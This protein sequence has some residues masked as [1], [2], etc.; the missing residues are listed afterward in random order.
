MRSG[1]AESTGRRGNTLVKLFVCLIASC[2]LCA[3]WPH[4]AAADDPVQAELSPYAPS[5]SFSPNGD[6]QEDT[7]SVPYCL[8]VASNVDVVVRDSAN[9]LVRTL[10]SGVSVPAT[11]YFNNGECGFFGW[12]DYP[13]WDGLNEAGNVVADGDYTIGI[14]A[15][16]AGGNTADLSYQTA[17]DTRLLG[18]LTQPA[19]NAVVSG[20]AGFVFVPT[21]GVDVTSVS[22]SC[23]GS[24][25]AVEADGTFRGSEDTHD[26][27]NG[28]VDVRAYVTFVDEFGTSH[29]WSPPDL[30]ITIDNPVQAVLSSYVPPQ[31]FSP[32]GDGQEDAIAIP[33]CLST[34][35]TV[36]VVVRDSA[37]HVVRTLESGVSV[38][39]SPYV[40]SLCGYYGWSDYPSWDGLNDAG[41]VV[42]DGDYTI[43][44]HAV[45]AGGNTADLSYQ[46]AVD[47]RLPG[48]LTQPAPNAAVSGTAGFVFVPTAGVDVTSVS[49]P[50]LGSS[51]DADAD[52]TFRGSEDTHDCANGATDVA[53]YVTFVDEF[54]TSHSWSPPTVP[55]T[56]DN[57]VQV[58]PVQADLG[59]QVSQ[60]FSPNGDGQE[61]AIAVPYC[62]SADSNVDVVVRDSANHV[63]RT[64][65]SG[66]SVPA[67]QYFN[68]SAC[69][70]YGWSDYPS[71]DGLN[72]AGNVVADGD[73][74][75]GIHAVDAGGNS[76]DLSYH[77][78][79]DTRVPGNLTQPAAND[80]LAGLAHFAFNPTAGVDVT[81]VSGCFSTGGCV[82]I[83]NPSPDGLWRTSKFTGQLSAGPATFSWSAQFTDEFG[84]VHSWDGTDVPVSINTTTLPLSVTATRTSGLVPL[85]TSFTINASDPNARPLNYSVS[86]GDGASTSGT[87]TSPYNPVVV[88]HSYATAGVFV[89]HVTI[90][91]GVG[92]FSQQ[93]QTITVSAPADDPPVATLT[94]SPQ[95]GVAPFHTSAAISASDPDNDALSYTLDWGDGSTTASGSIPSGSLSHTYTRAGAFTVRLGVGD[96]Q[97]TTVRTATVNVGLSEPLAANP[98]DDVQAVVGTPVA[99]DGSASRPLIG[100]DS[101]TWNFGDGSPTTTGAQVNHVFST[102][103][104]R[105]VSLT[106]RSGIHTSTNTMTVNVVPV[107]TVPGLHV[108][109]TD[110]ATSVLAGADVT[111]ID[112]SGVRYS[113]T[114]DASGIA[115][116]Q[117]LQDGA[118]SVYAWLD[119]YLPGTVAATI[120]GGTGH[121]ELALD[122]GAVA[123]TALTADRLTPQQ[124]AAVG[125]DP[126]DPAN[127]NAYQFEIHLAF[128][129]DPAQPPEDVGFSGYTIGGGGSGGGGGAF[130]GAG[131][132]GGATCTSDCSETVGNYTVY[133][134]VQ[135]IA[136]QPSI[137]W[138][139]IPGKAK[140][141]KEFFDVRLVV[142]NLASDAFTLQNGQAS[143]DSLPQGLSLA[144]TAAPQSLT[145]AVADIPGGTSQEAD[146]IIRG[147]TEGLYT[148]TAD[149]TGSL[150]PIG[151]S[152]SLPASTAPNAL[153]VWGESAVKMIVDA[154]DHATAAYPYHVR[155]GLQNVA[156]IPVYNAG[157]EL[158]TQGK[159]NY[160]YQPR[161]QLAQ[162]DDVIQPGSTFW[163]S[164]VLVPKISGTLDLTDSFVKKT[165]GNVDPPDLIESHPAVI[166]PANA[167]KF[168][169][170]R[171]AH[172]VAFTWDDVAGASNYQL[173]STPDLGTDFPGSPL[174][175]TFRNST[176]AY[177]S[178]I[179]DT[180]TGWYALSP[181]IAGRP[182]LHHPVLNTS[183]S[184]QYPALSVQHQCSGTEA[185]V[186]VTD[187]FFS[188][189]SYTITAQGVAPKTG[190]LSGQSAVIPVTL[191]RAH[192]PVGGYTIHVVNS[193]LESANTT[194]SA[195]GCSYFALGDSYSSG[196]GAVTSPTQ[197]ESGTD[198][199]NIPGLDDSVNTCH[200]T[201]NAYSGLLRPLINTGGAPFEFV[202]CSGA[203]TANI[204]TTA[205]FPE[206]T[207]YG[208][209]PQIQDLKDFVS[210]YGSP[211]V[212]TLS[213]GGNDA[214]FKS[215]IEQ[216]LEFDCTNDSRSNA[217]M[218]QVQAI[219]TPVEQ[220]LDAIKTAAPGSEIY[221]LGYPIPVSPDTDD[222]ASLGVQIGFTPLKL[223]VQ[224]RDWVAQELSPYLDSVVE[225]AAAR[226]GVHYVDESA[227][228][229]HHEI[230]SSAPWIHGI[231][232]NSHI[233]VK[234]VNAI[235]SESF[236]PDVNGQAAMYRALK[237]Q[238]GSSFGDDPN[239]LANTSVTAPPPP[240]AAVAGG[241]G[242]LSFGV[243][244][245]DTSIITRG[246]SIGLHADGFVSGTI[247]HFTLH[248]NPL[249]LGQATADSAGT[250]VLDATIPPGTDAGFHAI[251]ADGVAANAQP[252]TDTGY[253]LVAATATDFDGD[254]VSDAHDNCVSAP[255]PN[256]SDVNGN[257]I[258]DVCDPYFVASNLPD[259]PTS[260]VAAAGNGAASVSFSAPASSFGNAITSYTASCTS[261]NG[262]S[263]GT[264]MGAVAPLAVPGLTTG[265]TYTCTV[266]ATNSHG[267]GSASAVSPPVVVGTPTVPS[268]VKA[269][270]LP[271]TGATGSLSV[272]FTASANNGAPITTYGVSCSSSNGGVTKTAAR[273][274]ASSAAITVAGLTTGKSYACTAKATNSRGAGLVSA[275]SLPV[276]LGSPAPPTAVTAVSGSTTTSTGAVK[277]SFT[278]GASNG[279][280]ITSYTA[281]CTSTN[282]GVTASKTGA[283]GPLTV[284]G[285]TTGKTYSCAVSATN[286]RGAGLTSTPSLSV[287]V[288]SPEAPVS[289]TAVPVS[290]AGSLNVS[291]TA[292]SNNGAPIASYEV[293]CT[294]SNAGL[295][296]TT[297]GAV[298][299]LT[300]SG[301]TTGKTYSCTVQATNLR[302]GGPGSAPSAAVIVGSPAAPSNVMAVGVPTTA[303]TGSLSVSFTAAA[304]NG[305][306]I[307][308]YLA[309]CVSSNGGVSRTKTGAASPLVV[310][311][312]SP[313]KTYACTVKA[314][315]SRGA[316]LASTASLPVIVGSPAAPANVKAVAVATTGATGSL[317]VSFTPGANNGATVTSYSVTCTSSNAGVTR[318]QNGTASPVVVTALTTGKMYTCAV[319]AANS[320]G[321]GLASASSLAV[322]VGSPAPP[323]SVTA[324][325]VAAGQIKVSFVAG[326]NNGA[327]TTSYTATCTSSN[328]GLTG[329]QTG[330]V[331]PLTVT[332]LTAGKN[333]ACT[334]KATNARGPG[335]SSAASATVLV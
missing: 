239:P 226:A 208:D 303:T 248:S 157:I 181:L 309:S 313:G 252:R 5:Q 216:C 79:V 29:S 217:I 77:T 59:G 165:A 125:I 32:N 94:L 166:T 282:L 292:G 151:T 293:T 182:D 66:V 28:P 101:Y 52:G 137:I 38:P 97:L 16:D 271:T 320:R 335:L 235:S 261:S 141:L 240:S 21:A 255:N 310:S 234:D 84:V 23:L 1:L 284:S 12:S 34:D 51:S 18:H 275:P 202:A 102:T 231:S 31:S 9:H 122:S 238:Y 17:V 219:F 314:T 113:A 178:G 150:E 258:G 115:T 4:F 30:S 215:I 188:L 14:H 325:K 62:L 225:A 268:N 104:T 176:S 114:T 68:N 72:D 56:I 173:Y 61:D 33:Y 161:E 319:R 80:T 229:R 170:Y 167:P 322:I 206:S 189:A 140:W 308:S 133:P 228:L 200:R 270:S 186:T 227:V 273:T 172:T 50:C 20:T 272:S 277:V 19:P 2:T 301:L 87:I 70:Y 305:A 35:A 58:D 326:A 190:T 75:I 136:N 249:D 73:Y 44:I 289:V 209:R 154:D 76:A 204:L 148:L 82:T 298:G 143:L 132:A 242:E 223:T 57:P 160:I 257:G 221:L 124:M 256:Q 168:Q 302:G 126:N 197:Y 263:A 130:Y 112:A 253:L 55:I 191:D 106:V 304:N 331:G 179:S 290:A 327:V 198:D 262:G 184:P 121:V 146:W 183:L 278:V 103:G 7:I 99:F 286:S 119:G 120:A 88:P 54:G 65:E 159:L 42:A 100:I 142:T 134:T 163:A 105:A 264:K 180:S 96:G 211:N 145:E 236:H 162:E 297:T 11:Q 269:V 69:G 43:G 316:G 129:P 265:K 118:Y 26:C 312:L 39:S 201:K 199:Q 89:A 196:E 295:T 155:I 294:S 46:T 323:T 171:Y 91:N 241:Y 6:G 139:V 15:V 90:A 10:E 109:V 244:G 246:D 330:P 36:D 177:V 324:V 296:G 60:S 86:F 123:Q 232:A 279:V 259:A 135:Y 95:S 212:V 45:D 280:T 13:S 193:H 245:A 218:H 138:M 8:S 332:A 108:T 237:T 92:G 152:V 49:V 276:T 93:S 230:C 25:S 224:E 192:P 233:S 67:T 250:A 98:G 251:E 64:L 287:T 187:P 116:L 210:S 333:Y 48:H 27:G 334:V 111:V 213:I 71:W 37:N 3:G 300:V 260:V 41:N 205:Q 254:G 63:V 291:F 147:D 110:H 107:P 158:L 195:D 22:V 306:T 288:G 266:K 47:T 40:N 194:V 185:T 74:T 164:Y 127:Q 175:A 283:A 222:C 53:A 318:S 144:P 83:F 24:S 285:L 153:H 117:G 156:D 78:A 281:S 169:M 307:T 214:G 311:A 247:V 85:S 174:P 207:V 81:Q 131:F 315:N 299:P 203:T 317:S 321:A 267:T 243:P 274:G 328:G 149:Y 220:T 128:T 329:A